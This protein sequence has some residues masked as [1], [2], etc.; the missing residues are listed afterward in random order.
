[1]PQI[2]RTNREFAGG[3]QIGSFIETFSVSTGD[4]LSFTA[5]QDIY[6]A[7][8]MNPGST[9]H[10]SFLFWNLVGIISS[11]TSASGTAPSANSVATAWYV[12]VGTNGNG[13]AISTW[14]FW[15]EQDQVVSDTPIQ[16]VTPP[17]AWAGGNA[18]AVSPSAGSGARVITAR[19]T[20]PLIV[21]ADFDHWLVFGS[22][23]SASAVLTVPQNT[24]TWGIAVYMHHDAGRVPPLKIY[25]EL[26]SILQKL[27]RL[28]GDPSPEDLTRVMKQVVQQGLEHPSSDLLTKTLAEIDQL[29][30][31]Q[32]KSASIEVR[33]RINRLEAARKMIESALKDKK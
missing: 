25:V 10:F 17:S 18:T 13:N 19:N 23:T 32:L 20:V 11:G 15:S 33:A 2:T 5:E 9:I 24:S 7:D 30:Q 8:P 22:G 28:G 16:S 26:E 4:P 31:A 21:D 14:A 1:M 3:G 6:I 29:D 27:L 12:R